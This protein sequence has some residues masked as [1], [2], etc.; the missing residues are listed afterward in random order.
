MNSQF[1]VLQGLREKMDKFIPDRNNITMMACDKPISKK[2][3]PNISTDNMV[4]FQ[5][6]S[7][8]IKYRSE[9]FVVKLLC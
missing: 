4:P 5:S 7:L 6:L 3:L 9:K 8:V 2:F 1:Y